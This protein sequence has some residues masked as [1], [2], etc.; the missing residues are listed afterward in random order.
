M[1]R[2]LDT[3]LYTAEI[4]EARW[5]RDG[6]CWTI[7]TRRMGQAI[8]IEHFDTLGEAEKAVRLLKSVG[9]EISE[10]RAGIPEKPRFKPKRYTWPDRR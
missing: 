8:G 4:E 7:Q 3:T 9:V 1:S 10:F 6:T 5:T 2:G